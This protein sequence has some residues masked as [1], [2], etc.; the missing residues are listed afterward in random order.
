[1]YHSFLRDGY[2]LHDAGDVG[3][4]DVAL[5]AVLDERKEFAE[6]IAEPMASCFTLV[7]H[8]LFAVYVKRKGIENADRA[9]NFNVTILT[10]NA[11]V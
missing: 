10:L 11:A 6:L 5:L 9:M 4:D 3:D 2:L 8:W 1:M 7:N